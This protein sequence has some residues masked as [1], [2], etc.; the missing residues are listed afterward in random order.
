MTEDWG[1]EGGLHTPVA[2]SRGK[3]HR[4]PLNGR[5]GG[6]QRL[7]AGF[8]EPELRKFQYIAESFARMFI[9]NLFSLLQ[10]C[11]DRFM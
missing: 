3:N 10:N 2:F 9:E 7:S 11:L 5:L 1:G 6:P 4:Y 8:G